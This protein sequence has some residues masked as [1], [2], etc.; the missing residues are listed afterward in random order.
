MSYGWEPRWVR[1]KFKMGEGVEV[2][3]CQD[4]VT[5]LIICPMCVDVSKL[6]PSYVEPTQM[7]I[8]SNAMLF[9]S[10]D[11]LFH[12]IR[13]HAKAGEWKGYVLSEE[14]EEEGEPEEIEEESAADSL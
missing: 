6:C 13:A 11:D 9:F 7:A 10:P 5:S 12:H 4:V 8:P 2:E 1:R 14:E 3:T